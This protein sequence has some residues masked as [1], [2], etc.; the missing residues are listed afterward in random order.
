MQSSVTNDPEEVLFNMSQCELY[1]SVSALGEAYLPPM[2]EADGMFIHATAV[3]THLTTPSNHLNLGVLTKLEETKPVGQT[4][5]GETHIFGDIPT[6]VT[7]FARSVY[8][9][10]RDAEGKCVSISGL[11]D[12][13]S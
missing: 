2:F 6:G 4:E 5:V 9:M 1:E 11:T 13:K 10:Q 7:G 8:E 12:D 3:M